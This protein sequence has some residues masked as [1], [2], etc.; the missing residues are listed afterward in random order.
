VE[1]PISQGPEKSRNTNKK[2]K[3][4][5]LTS[6]IVADLEKPHD[7]FQEP[8]DGH[9]EVPFTQASSVGTSLLAL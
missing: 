9:Q 5:F 6:S 7:E 2:G 1:T 3:E 4:M 8:L